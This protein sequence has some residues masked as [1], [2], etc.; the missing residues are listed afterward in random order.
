MEELKDKILEL[1]ADEYS[2][3]ESLLE[4]RYSSVDEMKSDA[5]YCKQIVAY[6]IDTKLTYGDR[7]DIASTVKNLKIEI[8]DNYIKWLT[9]AHSLSG[10]YGNHKITYKNERGC[11]EF[12][13]DEW[14]SS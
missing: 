14:C 10:L 7:F 1:I 13:S 8:S 12:V 5:E 4:A 11:N 9:R 2:D 6:L 3:A